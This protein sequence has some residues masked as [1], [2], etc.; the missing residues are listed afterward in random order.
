MYDLAKFLKHGNFARMAFKDLKPYHVTD[1]LDSTKWNATTQHHALENVK[2]A[3]RWSVDQQRIP[4]SPIDKMRVEKGPGRTFT[5]SPELHRKL[6]DGFDDGKS[7]R[8]RVRSMRQIL[9]ALRLTGCR[10]SEIIKL[11]IEQLGQ[12]V[13][14]IDEHKTRRHGKTRTIYPC[15]CL[16]TLA[17]IAS[18]GR[19]TGPVFL[20]DYKTPWKY[21]MLRQRME[22]AKKRLNVD[23]D[24]VLYSYR[25]ASITEA[26]LAGVDTATVAEMHGTS[27]RVIES[28]YAHVM[29]HASH[30]KR[31]A[32]DV[33]KK[34]RM[35]G[36]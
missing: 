23:P 27:I 30:V 15:P 26:L 34:R 3:I 35:R 8:R 16:E 33:V 24:C 6:F 9:I 20:S 29:Q 28:T 12:E 5:I 14:R 7:G 36:D 32:F 31:A 19:T 4:S 11:T 21:S 18:H 1:W 22:R 10:P 13:W 2:R 17:R 25:H